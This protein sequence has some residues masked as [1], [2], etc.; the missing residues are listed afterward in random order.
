MNG[1]T[2][3]R[4]IAALRYAI[5]AAHPGPVR[6]QNDFNPGF[7]LLSE[8]E[9]DSAFEEAGRQ[10]EAGGEISFYEAVRRVAGLLALLGDEHTELPFARLD[11]FAQNNRLPIALALEGDAL[12]IVGSDAA[13]LY[14]GDT[15]TEINGLPAGPLIREMA[16]WFSGTAPDMASALLG[17][18]L[19]EALLL[20]FDRPSALDIRCGGRSH[21]LAFAGTK[22]R[23]PLKYA[24]MGNAMELTIHSFTG[25][26]D[27]FAG[28]IARMF[29]DIAVLGLEKLVIDLRGNKGGVTAYGDLILDRVAQRP[30][31]QLTAAAIRISPL[32]RAGFAQY[33]P[34]WLVR[35]G[36][37]R[38]IPRYGRLF[39]AR[40]GAWVDVPFK[41]VTPRGGFAG[42]ALEVWVDKASMST[43]AL[44]AAAVQHDGIGAIIGETG[45]FPSH[46]GNQFEFVLPETGLKVLIPV[47]RN[48]GHGM[49]RV[50]G[51]NPK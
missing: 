5:L 31:S 10:A 25:P 11:P 12:V 39:R 7:N 8:A 41:P 14:P 49:S 46:F 44:F 15:I 18:A 28:T 4:D 23:P 37:H 13:G 19:E 47:S 1:K 24:A 33:M 3:S 42:L 38:C 29:N 16:G 34:P 51:K 17:G 36:L 20:R 2:L 30:F 48:T 21:T 35:T 22:A 26:Q 43:A 6:E 45:G 50:L 27:T 32:S 9:F 40:D